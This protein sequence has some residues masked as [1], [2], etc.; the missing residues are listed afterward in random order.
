MMDVYVISAQNQ[1]EEWVISAYADH[2][3]RHK[4]RWLSGIA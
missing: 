2:W 1:Y 3:K 4:Q